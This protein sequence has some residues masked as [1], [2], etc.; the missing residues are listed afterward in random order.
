MVLVRLWLEIVM[1]VTWIA[2]RLQMGVWRTSTCFRITAAGAN[3]KSSCSSDPSFRYPPVVRRAAMSTA[4]RA[5]G[6]W[7][8]SYSPRKLSRSGSSA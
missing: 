1:T 5:G 3:S 2:E 7:R 4:E 8:F 6:A